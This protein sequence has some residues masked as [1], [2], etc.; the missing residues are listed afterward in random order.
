MDSMGEP[1]N[2]AVIFLEHASV[3]VAVPDDAVQ[4]EGLLHRAWEAGRAAWPHVA[5]SADAFVRHLAR[6]LPQSSA[7]SPLA[8]LL[9]QL[10]LADLYLA[11]ACAHHVP[12]AIQTLEQH[13]LAKLPAALAYLKQPAPVLDDV[14]QQV[15]IHLLLGTSG[16]GPRL[17]EYTGRGALLSWIRVIAVRMVLKQLTPVQEVSDQDV[18]A[19]VAALPALG[20]D[21]EL[22][23]IKHR[24]R[25][26]FRQAVREAFAALSSEQRH[27][28]RLHF[29]D[30]LSTIELGTL[31][32]VN[33]STVSRWL[34]SA[35]EAVYEETKRCFQE[36]LGLS[37][38]EFA[39]LLVALESQLDMS[40]SQLLEEE[41]PG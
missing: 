19:A 4:F 18:L 22:D 17:A 5:L 8:P 1:L 41:K 36:R 6:Q 15:R 39:S 11:C 37:S 13:H 32:R 38:Q 7:G 35:R 12:G 40:F 25:H 16:T 10:I 29:S 33:Q 27:L 20:P 2:L 26:E 24:Y 30:R 21:P 3:R 31:F 34:K 14:C 23:F 9:E 28:L